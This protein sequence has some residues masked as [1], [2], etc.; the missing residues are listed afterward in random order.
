LKVEFEGMEGFHRLKS[1]WKIEYRMVF[2][3]PFLTRG[4][5]DELVE[6]IGNL[7]HRRLPKDAVPLV[8][9]DRAVLTGNAVKGVFRHIISAQ[10]TQAGVDVCFQ[11]VKVSPG[12]SQR[13]EEMG[14]VNACQPD[15]PCFVC[16]WF[17]TSGRQGALHFSFL[18]STKSIN[19]ILVGEPIPMVALAEDLNALVA[20]KGRGAFAL[21][22]PVKE[23][24]EFRGWITG[25]N[26]SM[27]ILGA[28]KEIA[29]M[30]EKGFV[31][32]G[33][34]KTRG[35]GSARIEILKIEKFNAAP[36]KLEKSYE[37]SEL[38]SFLEA[39][40][41]KYHLLLSRGRKP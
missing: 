9:G 15:N 2:M 10:L 29:D 37:G 32:F 1:L 20:K 5:S 18:K 36:F 22:A 25:E 33:G 41:R 38:K 13:I 17:G 26:L 11:K 16:A 35:F 21:L 24:T 8:M 3:E 12:A 31:R 19:E 7:I 6:G 4:V 30:S 28:I 34:L 39:C 14:R 40:Q 27:E 23:N